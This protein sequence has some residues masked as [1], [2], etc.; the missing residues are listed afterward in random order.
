M[1]NFYSPLFI[2]Y[3][4]LKAGTNQYFV[5]TILQGLKGFDIFFL[6]LKLTINLIVNFQFSK[7]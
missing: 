4:R 7:S 3:C 2:Y 6:L 1:I 5:V